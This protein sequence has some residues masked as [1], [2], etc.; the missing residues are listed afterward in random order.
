MSHSKK[1]LAAAYQLAGHRLLSEDDLTE[2]QKDRLTNLLLD[3]L[4]D[5]DRYR[6][7]DI[8]GLVEMALKP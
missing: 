8:R 1:I 2:G 5:P 7:S 4:S 3:I 6:S